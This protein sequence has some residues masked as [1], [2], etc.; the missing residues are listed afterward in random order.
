MKWIGTPTTRSIA[1]IGGVVGS[2]LAMTPATAGATRCQ[3]LAAMALGESD[4][5]VIQATSAIQ[6]A[7]GP[8]R[9]YCLVNLEVKPSVNIAVGLPLNAA[10]G[11]S[12][13][14]EGSWNGRAENL[15]GGGFAGSVGVVTS[16]TNAGYVGSSTDTG[17]SA[18]WC[19][20]TDPA[21][22]KAN[23]Q[24]DCGLGGGGFELTPANQLNKKQ[25]A[26][27]IDQSLVDQVMWSRRLAEK[28]YGSKPV[29]NYW[30]GCSTG[31]RQGFD[32]A[33]NHSELFD[34]ILAGAPAFNWNRFQIAE[35]WPAVVAQ[36]YVGAAGISPAKTAAANAAAVAACD[37]LDGVTD[38][39]INEP[40]RCKFNAESLIC[41]KSNAA[42]C[43]TAQEAKAINAIWDG[44]R[45][46]R[47]QR[48]W[49]GLEYGSDFGV[50]IINPAPP[51]PFPF[52]QVWLQD[53]M[54]QDPNFPVANLTTANFSSYFQLSDRKFAEYPA[55]PGWAVSAAT[56][57]VNFDKLAGGHAT[58]IIHYHGLSDP[59]IV[60]F[61][62]W[63]YNSRVFERYG[64]QEASKFYRS[65]YFPGNG[66]CG[67]NTPGFLSGGNFPNAGLIN[68]ND[69]FGALVKWVEKGQA[70]DKIV[71]YTGQN[72]TGATRLICKYP[73]ESVYNGT[74]ST[75]NASNYHC[76]VHAKEP[77][78]LQS[79]DQ[80]ARQ[81]FE[82]P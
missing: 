32:L 23:A 24:P 1:L 31:G 78:E 57:S 14:L 79:F 10:D 53:W 43:L 20:A 73:D 38:G 54:M 9:A 17:H 51:I 47:G 30:N 72:D 34:G 74:G 25:I 71:A 69:L 35:L 59:L 33:Q 28:Y 49:G 81:Y 21:T 68:Q 66:H 77:A 64:V 50:L 55:T 15:G 67:G 12:G 45:N 40:R 61:G 80:T 65:F 48:L 56:D 7:N 2:L 27:F 82:A 63:N 70:P 16:A 13:A 44:P 11:G 26:E 3:A 58:K 76:K 18:A 41:G 36:E 39:V 75:L 42:T 6:P 4:G 62:S 29:R 8:D 60:P 5:K 22:G 52:I 46:Q 37:A 19:N